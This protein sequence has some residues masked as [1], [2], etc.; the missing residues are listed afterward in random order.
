M[1]AR[2]SARTSTVAPA[3][4]EPT[5]D[6]TF[7]KR[8]TAG[9]RALAASSPLDR[10]ITG[11]G[12]AKRSRD[13]PDHAPATKR[14]RPEDPAVARAALQEER[15]ARKRAKKAAAKA[16]AEDGGTAG[17]EVGVVYVGHIPHGFY[18]KQMRRF[19]GQFGEVT[20]LRVS[21]SKK[22]ARSRGFAFVEFSNAE[23]GGIAA[24]AMD[25]YLMHGR[26]LVT[27]LM[28][29]EDVHPDTFIGADRVFTRIPWAG[30]ERKRNTDA[31]RNPEKLASRAA[32]IVKHH[33]KIQQRL[34]A[35]GITYKF[36]TIA[37]APS[38]SMEV[39]KPGMNR[40]R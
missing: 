11:G 31:A 39:T 15:R 14:A 20:R 35:R 3:T 36:P 8:M 18:E 2:K 1:P 10:L 28:V 6:V 22:T 37:G 16:E 25:G 12:R 26:A 19:F 9:K 29:P 27:K 33:E 30:I 32:N 13:E 23:V 7:H 24:K 17:D 4:P 21:R 40:A 5:P 34:I 38:A